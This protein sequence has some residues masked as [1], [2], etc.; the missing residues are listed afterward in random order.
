M[1]TSTSQRSPET[2]AWNQVRSLYQSGMS[3][4]RV[5]SQ[6]IAGALGA[7]TRAAMAGPGVALCL[8]A[9]L[10]GSERAAS[11]SGPLPGGLSLV[12]RIRQ[13]AER[14]IAVGGEASRWS[15]LALDALGIAGL[16]AA[17]YG[18]E[19]TSLEPAGD[20]LTLLGAFQREGRL[21]QLAGLFAGHDLDRCFRHLVSRDLS[22]Y[23]GTAAWP[24][25][26][27]ALRLYDGVGAWCR[28][29]AQRWDAAPLEGRLQDA[30]RAGAPGSIGA[31]RETVTRLLQEGLH[32]LSGG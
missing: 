10:R 24:G 3:D 8:D 26:D 5:I 25:T 28:R 9:L 13:D 1:G 21:H 23:V 17:G 29:A 12:S 30:V 27:E 7:G 19:A 16:E 6:A 31:A 32:T 15:D 18:V 2:A 14:R 11:Q 20:P 4:P 22:E